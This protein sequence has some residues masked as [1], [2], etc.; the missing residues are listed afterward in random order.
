MYRAQR[1]GLTAPLCKSCIYYS[2]ILSQKQYMPAIFCVFCKIFTLIL[3]NMS[4][5]SKSMN[6]FIV[7]ICRNAV[8]DHINQC[9]NAYHNQC[10]Y[11]K[12]R[13]IRVS[14]EI[15]HTDKDSH[16]LKRCC[17]MHRSHGQRHDKNC[18]YLP[19]D[20]SFDIFFINTDFH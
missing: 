4:D 10:T 14:H 15:N 17:R 2:E 19:A 8:D 11:T 3:P 5:I 16:H 18:P 9:H 12:Y 13:I 20:C 1:S 6:I 7:H